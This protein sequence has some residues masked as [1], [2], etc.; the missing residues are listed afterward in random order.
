MQTSTHVLR[1]VGTR[2][3]TIR[4]RQHQLGAPSAIRGVI[5][6]KGLHYGSLALILAD[7]TYLLH[8]KRRYRE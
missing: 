3:G 2:S 1:K 4:L 7:Q 8:R 6:Q 5:Q